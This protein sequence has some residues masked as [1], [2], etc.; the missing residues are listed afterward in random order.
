MKKHVVKKGQYT[1]GC[2]KIVEF[3]GTCNDIICVVVKSR[4]S[5][6]SWEVY[7]VGIRVCG[8]EMKS[9]V[10]GE[11]NNEGMKVVITC[12]WPPFCLPL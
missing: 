2:S 11:V 3:Y 4:A 10:I 1:S 9:A 5:T 6:I 7:I 12:R 8:V